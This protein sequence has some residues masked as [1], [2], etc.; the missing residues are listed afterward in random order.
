[1][2]SL[3]SKSL[4]EKEEKAKVIKAAGGL[5]WLDSSHGR[6]IAI[7]HRTNRYGP[8]WVLPKGKVDKDKNEDWIDTAKREVNE[9][10]GVPDEELQVEN[11]AGSLSYIAEKG[12]PKIVVM[13]NM[14]CKKEYKFVKKQKDKSKESEQ[15][16]KPEEEKEAEVDDVRWVTVPEALAKLRYPNE[17]ALLQDASCLADRKPASILWARNMFPS[18]SH[19]RLD[20]A[21]GPFELEIKRKI[22]DMELKWREDDPAK[23]QMRTA[24]GICLELIACAKKALALGQVELGWRF[25]VEADLTSLFLIDRLIDRTVLKQRAVSTLVES[26]EKLE[27]WRKK[28]VQTLLGEDGEV[29]NNV[30]PE[31]LYASQKILQDHH[32]NT[33]IK[34]RT[35][36]IQLEILAIIA[37]FSLISLGFVLPRVT[38]TVDFNDPALLF[39]IIMLGVTGGCFSGIFSIAREANKGKIP[40]RLLNSWVTISR[41]LV[42]AMAALAISAFLLAGLI[43]LGNLNRYIIFALSFAV[44]FSERLLVKAIESTGGS[45]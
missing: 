17:R 29:K 7:V 12:A 18:L 33:Y 10:T 39:S 22:S 14:S 36:Q 43:Q 34:L 16:K 9:E 27:G 11:V 42:G 35:A 28:T 21:L 5:V 45:S 15:A 19:K 6:K 23:Q 38:D 20:T 24:A 32:T 13:Y 4:N 1:V 25:L 31:E 44:G 40:D 41:P 26:E 30:T 3:E 37:I 2:N 8:E